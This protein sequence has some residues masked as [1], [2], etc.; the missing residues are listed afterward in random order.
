[1]FEMRRF[2][3]G[4][5]RSRVEKTKKKTFRML[6]GFQTLINISKTNVRCDRR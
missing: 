1:M 5:G 2:L 6:K 3:G 4:V